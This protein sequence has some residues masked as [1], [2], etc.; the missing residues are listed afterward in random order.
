MC[1]CFLCLTLVLLVSLE[2][3]FIHLW[4]RYWGTH[5]QRERGRENGGSAWESARELVHVGHL[6][7]SGRGNGVGCQVER[8]REGGVLSV[9]NCFLFFSLVC[10]HFATVTS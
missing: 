4:T 3:S 2:S 9:C 1:D 5:T 10:L 7:E 6:A 8:E